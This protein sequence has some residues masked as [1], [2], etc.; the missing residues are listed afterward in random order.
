MGRRTYR[1]EE[2]PFLLGQHFLCDEDVFSVV[3]KTVGE[4]PATLLA[5]ATNEVEQTTNERLLLSFIMEFL[6]LW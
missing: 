6:L 5:A 1:G 2:D 4:G 3:E